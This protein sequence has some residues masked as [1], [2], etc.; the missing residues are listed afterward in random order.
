[1]KYAIASAVAVSLVTLLL[2]HTALKECQVS[3]MH[4]MSLCGWLIGW[5]NR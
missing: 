5:S 3:V 1:V 4:V 2:A